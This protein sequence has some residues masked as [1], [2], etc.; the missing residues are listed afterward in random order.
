MVQTFGKRFKSSMTFSP[1]FQDFTQLIS[2]K[3]LFPSIKAIGDR[4]NDL[5]KEAY[6]YYEQNYQDVEIKFGELI[7]L[8]YD[9]NVGKNFQ[10]II[11]N[12]NFR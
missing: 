3:D 2:A 5:L 7:F 11:K 10:S 9:I 1:S 6:D 8:L 12:L 4:L